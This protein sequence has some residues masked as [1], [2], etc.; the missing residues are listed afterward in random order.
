LRDGRVVAG[1]VVVREERGC[2]GEEVVGER[3]EERDTA[4]LLHAADHDVGGAVMGFE[5]R[6]D[7]LAE[8]GS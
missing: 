7:E 5:V 4:D 6:V 1:R 2:V 3:A 8:T